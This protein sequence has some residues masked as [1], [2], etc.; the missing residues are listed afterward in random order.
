MNARSFITLLSISSSLIDVR[1]QETVEVAVFEL[2]PHSSQPLAYD[3]TELNVESGQPVRLTL[4]NTGSALP[5]PHNFVLVKPGKVD[6]VGAL[7]TEMITDPV[8]LEKS[9]IPDSCADILAFCPLV[10]PG[11]SASIEFVAPKEAGD[12]P[13]ICTF[14]GHWLQMRGILHVR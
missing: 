14:P 11:D 7:A 3:Q 10:S 8:A 12:Y 4:S 2:K 1:G 13:Y 6:T 9:Y 5:Q